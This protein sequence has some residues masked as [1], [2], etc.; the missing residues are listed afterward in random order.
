MSREPIESFIHEIKSMC[1]SFSGAAELLRTV[2]N[3]E[4]EELLE[5]IE[6]NARRLA[7]LSGQA[8]VD[9]RKRLQDC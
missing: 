7:Q 1:A 9:Q 8:L 3:K 2:S 6:Q 5:L 4:R